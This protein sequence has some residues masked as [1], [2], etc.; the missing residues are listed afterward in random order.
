MKKSLSA[1][2]I[3]RRRRIKELACCC[4]G[5]RSDLTIRER[6]QTAAGWVPTLSSSIACAVA[7]SVHLQNTHGRALLAQYICT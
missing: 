6:S 3:A 7:V 4:S 5:I 2:N 1:L